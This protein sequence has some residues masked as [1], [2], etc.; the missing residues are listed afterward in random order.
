ML[1]HSHLSREETQIQA[2]ET[3]A[4][5][6][7]LLCQSQSSFQSRES[8]Q[9]GSSNLESTDLIRAVW[10]ESKNLWLIAGPSIFSRVA[11]FSLTVVTQA[12]AGHLGEL[13][14]AA[15][16]MVCFVIIGISFGFLLGMASALETL[17]GQAYGAKQYHMLGIYMQ[18]SWIVLFLCSLLLL[19]LFL[20]AA[21]LLKLIGQPADVAEKTGL[22]AL[23]LI[24][25]HLSFPFQFTL[26]RFLQCQLKAGV[27]AWVSG[28]ALVLHVLVSWVFVHKLQVGIVG[29]AITIDFSWWVTVLAMFLYC[30]CGGCP[31]CWTGFSDQAFLGL[32][33][34]FKLAVASGVMLSL[35]NF[36][37]KVLIIVSGYMQ[38]VKVAIDALSI[39]VTIYTWESMIPLGFLAAA[40]Y[41]APCFPAKLVLAIDRSSINGWV[42]PLHWMDFCD[43][44]VHDWKNL[45]AEFIL[46][47][48]PIDA[49]SRVRVA[50]ELGAGNAKGAQFA[51][52]VS[53]TTSAAVG[54]FF[55]IIIMVF[56]KELAAIFTSSSSVI[57]MVN[58]LA[59]LLA[60]TVLLNSIQPVLSGVAVGSGWQ[61]SVAFVNIGSYYIVGP[62]GVLFGSWLLHFGIQGIW[63]GMLA[64]TVVQ[65]LVLTV[66][67]LRCQ[68]EKEVSVGTRIILGICTISAS[69]S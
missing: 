18:R 16:S 44:R 6:D 67:T 52:I 46:S 8:H 51:T 27:V 32:W 7:H 3:A 50:N 17:C 49:T 20:F 45:S 29:A 57:S 28:G 35:E 38:N 60:F 15:I 41:V 64:G 9:P 55:G 21:P 56:P 2:M 34:F 1:R 47:N 5:K 11:M 54:L 13:N 63:V 26:Q 40:G 10:Q 14:L 61:A 24:P 62:L 19:P 23:W 68:W 65:T 59:A 53:V 12:F 69:F 48:L 36:Y 33:D 58:E 22:V 66:M 43:L 25:F 4:E 39:C 30:V 42:S 31:K 37:Y